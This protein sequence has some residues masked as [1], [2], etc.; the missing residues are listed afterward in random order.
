MQPSSEDLKSTNAET[1]REEKDPRRVPDPAKQI[2]HPGI[3]PLHAL[4]FTLMPE[5][6]NRVEKVVDERLEKD[7]EERR[8]KEE[9]KRRKVKR[10]GKKGNREVPGLGITASPVSMNIELPTSETAP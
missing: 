5:V 1:S 2:Y 6:V 3:L 9:K 8:V 4:C 10:T 7:E